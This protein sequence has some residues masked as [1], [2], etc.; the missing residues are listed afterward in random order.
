MRIRLAFAFVGALAIGGLLAPSAVADTAIAPTVSKASASTLV[1]GT[2]G[3]KTWTVKVTAGD[4]SGVKGVKV[5]PWP[6]VLETQYD[7][8]PTRSDVSTG[9][10]AMSCTASG[11][12]S[13]CT[14]SEP[15][16]VRADL[17]D[18]SAAGTW[19]A[20]VLVNGKD[21]GTLYKSKAATFA[22]KRQTALTV[23]AS[24]EPVKKG[25]TLTATGRL[26]RADWA[27]FTWRGYGK[28]P[29][30]LQFR[31]AGTSTYT[32][33]KTVYTDSQGNL[34]TTT[35]ANASGYW[36]WSYAGISVSAAVDS[37]NDHVAI[38]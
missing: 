12:T 36:R 38:G 21:G 19:Y 32:T 18:N 1:F 5:L 7:S 26:T 24:P 3:T 6:K 14:Y 15:V 13:T 23:N 25:G 9:G 17:G 37:P 35:T 27:D 16:D 2:S 30:K 31:K 10:T 28:Q 20:A 33:V 4:D 11:T 8:A 34:R 29:V 22:F